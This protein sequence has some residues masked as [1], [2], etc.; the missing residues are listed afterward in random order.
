MMIRARAAGLTL[1]AITT[2]AS[3]NSTPADAKAPTRFD[4]PA[5]DL[6]MSIRAIANIS[7]RQIII[8]T[9]AVEG[10]IAPAL[11]GAFSA[12]EAITKLLRGTGVTAKFTNEAVLVGGT[13]ASETGLKNPEDTSVITVT[14]TRIRGG[15]IASPVYSYEVADLKA[16]GVTDMRGAAAAIPQNFGGGQNP[17][18]GN[19]AEGFG[20]ENGDSSTSLNLR[21]LGPDATLTLLNGHRV[22]YD[23]NSQSVDLTSIPLAAVERIEVMPDGASALYGSDAVGGVVNVV[24]KH[25]FSGF[26]TDATIGGATNGGDFT[27]IYDAAGGREWGTGSALVTGSY[28]R[29]DGVTAGDRSFTKEM[30]P[31]A[32]LFPKIRSYGFVADGH[33]ELSDGV[34]FSLDA[35]YNKRKYFSATPYD[36]DLPYSAYGVTNQG[37]AATY[38]VAPNI[39]AKLS[40][41]SLTLDGVYGRSRSDLDQ[42]LYSPGSPRQSFAADY[43]NNTKIVE[44]QGEGPL[45]RLPAG[46]IR[47]ALGAGVKSN[48][49][50]TNRSSGR[51]SGDQV[52]HYGFAEIDIPLISAELG[53]PAIESLVFTGAYRYEA[54]RNIDKVGTPKLGLV[55]RPSDDLDV[56]SSW[57]KSFKAPTLSQEL[58]P[59]S[60]LLAPVA[61]FGVGNAPV[62]ANVLYLSGGNP[63]LKPERANSFALTGDFHPRSIPGLL[64]SLTY[65]DVKY[66]NR[67]V[68]PISSV[69]SAL[70]DPAY[71]GVVQKEPSASDVVNVLALAPY[72]VE[73]LTG[74]PVDPSNLYAVLDDR[75]QNVARQNLHGVDASLSYSRP[76]TFAGTFTLRANATYLISRQSLLAGEPSVRLAGTIFR[77]PN[78]KARGGIT[79]GKGSISLNAT[80]SYIGPVDDTRYS[81]SPSVRGMATLDLSAAKHIAFSD[82][83]KGFDVRLTAVNVFNAK[84]GLIRT[85]SSIYQPYDFTNYSAIGRFLSIS[86]SRNW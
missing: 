77:P 6:G 8:A 61:L 19:G 17:G 54:Y 34:T 22:V 13:S 26:N 14:G 52:D 43:T 82:G 33:Q 59:V 73:N 57:G 36:P 51:T 40:G 53:I 37:S 7:G 35:Y 5:Q 71:S 85:S 62:A 23:Q 9:G 49:L 65:F 12:D 81:P 86:V 20:S 38:G 39:V 80:A 84:P 11:H 67:I 21:G 29:N 1:A 15:E 60:A 75:Y 41:W 28:S 2:L 32:S 83:S 24:L 27:Q 42:L 79:W 47:V 58:T 72:A 66:R 31:D 50:E 25:N 48:A 78:F 3:T 44:I 64:M 55:W 74:A 46:D 69:E 70:D 30:N 76:T 16:E 56:K 63:D 45:I 18:V 4:L 10:K 68:T